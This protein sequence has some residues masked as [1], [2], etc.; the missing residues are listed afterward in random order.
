MAPCLRGERPVHALW[1]PLS[2][3]DFWVSRFPAFPPILDPLVDPFS[4]PAAM[5]AASHNRLFETLRVDRTTLTK[6]PLAAQGNDSAYWCAQT[7]RRRL[8]ALEWLR[9][10]NYR[11]DPDTARLSRLH[12]PVKRQAR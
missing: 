1:S 10:L 6:A 8:A 12:R 7:P 5:P 2:F 11:Y 9:Q 4:V 3:R